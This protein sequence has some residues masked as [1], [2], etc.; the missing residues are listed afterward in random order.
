M[1]EWLS[2]RASPCQGES[3]VFDPRLPLPCSI[4]AATSPSGKARLCK[5]CTSGSNPLVAS[6]RNVID[7]SLFFF[8]VRTLLIMR[9][10]HSYPVEALILKRSDLGEADRILTLFTPTKCKFRSIAK[11]IRRPVSKKAGHLEL[12]SHSQLQIALG[13]N[14][15]IVTQAEIR[16]NFLQLRTELWHMTC[17]LYLAELVDRFIEDNTQHPEVYSLMLEILRSLE[18][19]VKDLQQRKLN[20]AALATNTAQE[21]QVYLPHLYTNLLLRYFE[22]HL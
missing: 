22:I 21:P 7:Q 11:G 13:R 12:L 16:E 4:Q 9:Q 17:G 18:A 3:R 2:G 6:L 8:C 5:S 15:D 20:G 19:D 10:Q 14:L 1:R